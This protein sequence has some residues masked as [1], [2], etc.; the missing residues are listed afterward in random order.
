MSRCGSARTGKGRIPPFG[1][2]QVGADVCAGAAS[3]GEVVSPVSSGFSRRTEIR[4]SPRS[5]TLTSTPV[6]R[7]LVRQRPAD[8]RLTAL[9]LE[10]EALEPGR[11]ALAENPLDADLVAR[12]QSRAAH[13]WPP[14]VA[15]A[16]PVVNWLGLTA[17]MCSV[18]SMWIC[19]L[20]AT[21]AR[22]A[23]RHPKVAMRGWN[24]LWRRGAWKCRPAPIPVPGSILT[25]LAYACVAPLRSWCRMQ[26]GE[27]S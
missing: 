4:H 22:R 25:V 6:Q 18:L 8:D 3:H 5:R 24:L 9:A 14:L 1:V 23:G 27:V 16:V 11:P 2:V 21:K 7:W 26:H 12:G 17:A 13:A 15:S 19:G 10:V 20:H